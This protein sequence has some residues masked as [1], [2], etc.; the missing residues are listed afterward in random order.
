MVMPPA[1]LGRCQD[2]E[3]HE[4]TH[5]QKRNP[6][7]H[8]AP[9]LFWAC[10]VFTLGRGDEG[11]NPRIDPLVKLPG[12][13]AGGNLVADDRSAQGIGKGTLQSVA[14]FN[15]ELTV[16]L[17]HEQDDTVAS[18][19][20]ADLPFF[21]QSNREIF[22]A[23]P[24]KRGDQEDGDLVRCLPLESCQLSFQNRD[25]V[26]REGSRAVRYPSFRPFRDRQAKCGK[27]EKEAQ[28]SR[29]KESLEISISEGPID[30]NFTFGAFLASCSAS[31]R[32]IRS[33][34]KRP[35]KSA[36]GKVRIFLL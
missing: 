17:H 33:N 7:L 26:T 16:I 1:G 30:Q 35:A 20:L 22:Q 10:L 5:N 9:L 14:H 24:L 34:P 28:N 2:K 18:A 29:K 21:G 13:E 23:V 32:G 11:V 27:A 31:K 25:L 4:S 3:K 8:L 12:F 19:L 6:C 36:P 15:P